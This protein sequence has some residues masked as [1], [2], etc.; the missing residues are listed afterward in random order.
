M[1]SLYPA[2]RRGWGTNK[3]PGEQPITH[4][5][6]RYS[7]EHNSFRQMGQLARGVPWK[8]CRSSLSAF[9]IF[10]TAF[11]SHASLPTTSSFD[12]G[13]RVTAT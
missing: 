8:D 5:L 1:S 3:G 6:K 9:K 2:F 4:I 7:H 11:T 13:G 10:L 12:N